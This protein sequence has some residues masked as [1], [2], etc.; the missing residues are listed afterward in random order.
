[1]RDGERNTYLKTLTIACSKI[2]FKRN[3]ERNTSSKTLIISLDYPPF[4]I[5]FASYPITPS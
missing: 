1:M 2:K 3:D 4:K 5:Y